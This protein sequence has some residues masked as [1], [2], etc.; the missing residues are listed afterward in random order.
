MALSIKFMRY[1]IRYNGIYETIRG[2]IK[3][4]MRNVL[5]DFITFEDKYI[6][7]GAL[8]TEEILKRLVTRDVNLYGVCHAKESVNADMLA[9]AEEHGIELLEIKSGLKEVIIDKKIDVFFIGIAQRF[10]S[11][12]LTGLQCKTY[13]LLHDISIQCIYNAG[14]D[15]DYEINS[16][17]LHGYKRTF[18]KLRYIKTR[19]KKAIREKSIVRA[20]L[21]F[22]KQYKVLDYENLYRAFR[23]PNVYVLTV[24]NYSKYAI[25]YYFPEIA[26]PVTVFYPAPIACADSV[27]AEKDFSALEGKNFFL[28]LSVN[29]YNKNA[30]IFLKQFPALNKK[31]GNHF[32]AVFVGF[33]QL[34]IEGVTSFE[35]VNDAE[36]R[37][38]QKNCYALVYPSL[39]EGFGLPP[40]EVMQYA[41]P[42]LAAYDTSIPEV[43]GGGA[44]YFNPLYQED[45]YAK[46]VEL[47]ENY[48]EWCKRASQRAQA[49]IKRQTSDAEALIEHIL[50][51]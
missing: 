39:G 1:S 14:L 42:V 5:F 33:E 49:V 18:P 30:G 45:L 51:E 20:K 50:A 38:L 8:V 47:I 17:L 11:Y 7:G 16:F 3:I 41:K 36:L 24:S 25:E 34:E 46:S 28:L 22:E 15:C 37:W 29:R 23:E 43:C 12:D 26:N 4:I 19:I 9:F 40:I 6:N 21:P 31:Y 48:D 44:L 35:R 2:R 27:V 32:H 10:A 13:L